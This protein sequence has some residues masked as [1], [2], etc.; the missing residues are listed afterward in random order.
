MQSKA[1]KVLQ[2]SALLLLLP[3]ISLPQHEQQGRVLMINGQ[4]GQAN[5][6][7]VDGRAY[8]DIEGLTQITHGS[9]SF[10]ANHIILSLPAPPVSPSATE[11]AQSH[12]PVSETGLSH[13]FMRAGI[14]QFAATREWGTTLSYAIQNGYHVTDAWAANYREQAAHDLGLASAAASTESDRS[15]LQLLRN[16]FEA[17]REWSNKLVQERKSMDTAKYALSPYAL[18]DDPTSQKII[19]CGRFLATMLGSG[20]FQ[21][22]PSCH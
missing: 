17:V 11:Q 21:D 14:E 2:I 12:S 16:E 4:A 13:E 1:W 10:N 5:V 8:V 6:V 7:E 15:A 20:R 9:L 22:D 19:T 3:G 18:R